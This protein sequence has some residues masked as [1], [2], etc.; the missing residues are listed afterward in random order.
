MPSRGS[1]VG[2]NTVRHGAP[3]R[4]QHGERSVGHEVVGGEHAFDVRQGG[5]HGPGGGAGSD[6]GTEDG[7]GVGLGCGRDAEEDVGLA[8]GVGEAGD[9]EAVVVLE[10]VPPGDSAEGAVVEGSFGP[11]R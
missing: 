3:G 11:S 2:V 5:Q 9:P 8:D 10:V 6:D 7:D 1:R 4:A